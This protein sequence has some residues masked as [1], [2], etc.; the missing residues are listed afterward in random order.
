MSK[1]YITQPVLC[2]DYEDSRIR[3]NQALCEELALLLGLTQKR[4]LVNSRKGH[5]RRG[6]IGRI[7]GK[8]CTG[9]SA[10]ERKEG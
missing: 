3:W 5:S 2:K 9:S 4:C 10:V 7:I 8:M 1:H 6:V